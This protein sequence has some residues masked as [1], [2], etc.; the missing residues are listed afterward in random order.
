MNPMVLCIAIC[1]SI[2]AVQAAQAD[3]TPPKIQAHSKSDLP[4]FS[5]HL[6]GTASALLEADDATFAVFASG[7]RADLDKVLATYDIEDKSTMRSLLGEK[8]QLQELAGDL[9]GA[10][11]TVDAV[12]LLEEKPSAKLTSGLYARARL[13][14]ALDT[15]GEVGAAYE[16]AF[17][18]RY[19][20]TI[21][22]LPWDV[23]Q[24]DIKASYASS[25][26]LTRSLLIGTVKTDIDPAALK[27]GAV[28]NGEAADLIGARELLKFGLPVTQARADVLHAYIQKNKVE[29]P[30]IWDA[31]EVTITAAQH[32][33]PVRVGI[34]DSGVDVALFPKQLFTDQKPTVSGRHGLAF[35]DDGTASQSW[36]YPLTPEQQQAYPQFREVITGLTDLQN[37]IDSPEADATL[38]LFSTFNPEQM[39]DMLEK[40][41]VLGHYL[42]G[43][44]VAGIA[45]RGNSMARLVV[46][47]FNDDLADLPFAPTEEWARRLGAD[48][49]RMAD[50]FRSRHVRVV[51]MSWGD[52]PEEFETWLSKTG[53]GGDPA[54]RKQHA[55][56]LF[57]LWRQAIESAIKSASGTLFV[58]AAGNSNNNVGFVEDVP[59]SLKLTNLL[60]VAAV[61]QAGDETSFTSHGENVG[62]AADGYHVM[63]FVPGGV[64]LRLSGTSMAAPNVTNLAAKLFA[65][66]YSLT[67]E[68]VIALIKDGSTPSDDGRQMLIDEK[69]SVELLRQRKTH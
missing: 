40:G 67:P 59:S 16:Q 45:V 37:G 44:H 64:R 25:R 46:A 8:Q 12:R 26:L 35:N 63:S 14:A 56:R 53:G 61:N 49:Q 28:D 66:D 39:H 43:T 13:R 19:R 9:R 24:D 1:A 36:L 17:T 31:R 4:R 18:S 34:W 65:L 2:T 41:K 20:E 55:A 11:E 21:E 68:Q 48:F 10:L 38:K 29:K 57:E 42:H 7:V 60:V 15:G 33:K 54:A 32:L 3:D 58:A 50:Y 6:D 62:V 51:N 27:S 23:V 22:P 30:D 52:E 69:R 5:Y 47:R